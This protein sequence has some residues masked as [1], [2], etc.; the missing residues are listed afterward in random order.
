MLKG[1]NDPRNRDV[2]FLRPLTHS[3]AQFSLVFMAWCSVI[4][5][6]KLLSVADVGLTK[7]HFSRHLRVWTSTVVHVD[8]INENWD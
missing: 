5:E 6:V 8:E 2:A 7:M 4:K 3:A 1:K